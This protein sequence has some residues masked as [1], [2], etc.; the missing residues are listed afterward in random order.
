[1]KFS[2][3]IATAVLFAI[4]CTSNADRAQLRKD[5]REMIGIIN[6]EY[7]FNIENVVDYCVAVIEK[8]E[9]DPSLLKSAGFIGDTVLGREFFNAEWKFGIASAGARLTPRSDGCELVPPTQWVSK[10]VFVRPEINR[11]YLVDRLKK[12]GFQVSE[13]R[14]DAIGSGAQGVISSVLLGVSITST[15]FQYATRGETEIEL[16]L[17]EA[18]GIFTEVIIRKPEP[19]KAIDK[20][21]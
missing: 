8:R 6:E 7:L 9:A 17:T 10:E 16:S 5:Q 18:G 14:E 15:D 12:L 11:T 1:M 20:S 3:L 19:Q 4:G 2:F 13:L 21:R